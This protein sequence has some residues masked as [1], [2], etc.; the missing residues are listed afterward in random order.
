MKRSGPA[1]RS[2][3][4]NCSRSGSRHGNEHFPSKTGNREQ[5]IMVP[6]GSHISTSFSLSLMLKYS[7][8]DGRLIWSR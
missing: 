5:K 3:D 7:L 2:K 6:R 1:S 4:D 8:K